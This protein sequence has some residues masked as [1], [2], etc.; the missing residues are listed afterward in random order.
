MNNTFKKFSNSALKLVVLLLSP[1]VLTILTIVILSLL[2]ASIRYTMGASFY[3][4]YN[5]VMGLPGLYMLFGI[6]YI[7]ATIGYVANE[8]QTY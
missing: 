2:V 5:I 1:I 3:E 4:S 7:L 6:V 8:T